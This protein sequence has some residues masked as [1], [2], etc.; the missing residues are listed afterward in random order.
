MWNETLN[1]VGV[2]ASSTLKR[3]ENVYYPPA[4]WQST[5]PSSSDP[6]ADT[7]TKGSEDDKDSPT[8]ILPSST[9]PSKEVGKTKAIKEKKDTTKGVVP[10]VTKP[11]A[12][13]KDP[14]EVKVTSQSQEPVLATLPI[15]VK[16][17]FKGKGPTSPVVA[18]AQI[19]KAPAKDKLVLKL[20]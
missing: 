5:L 2:E 10:E 19:I 11:P 12:V 6:K 1:L 8:E 14:S 7:T 15:P 13:P 17:D 16:E 18:A 20:K 4:I 9:D 3:A